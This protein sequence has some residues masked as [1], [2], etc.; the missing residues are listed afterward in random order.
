MPSKVENNVATDRQ[1]NIYRYDNNGAVQQRTPERTWQPA[2]PTQAPREVNNVQ[3]QR[4]RA[5]VRTQ[6]FS[7]SVPAPTPA[8]AQRSY[9]APQQRSSG[10]GGE[11]HR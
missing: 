8:P 3:Q 10:G 6:N 1:G 7:R 11:R 9:S 5:D 2:A 4:E